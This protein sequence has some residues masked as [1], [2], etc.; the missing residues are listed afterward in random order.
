M[1]SIETVTAFVKLL[2]S[3]LHNPAVAISVLAS[4]LMLGINNYFL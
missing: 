4:L 1:T 3:N 2:P